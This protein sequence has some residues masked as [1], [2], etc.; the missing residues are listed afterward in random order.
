MTKNFEIQNEI[1]VKDDLDKKPDDEEKIDFAKSLENYFDEVGGFLKDLQNLH[2]IE[3]FDADYDKFEITELSFVPC[4]VDGDPIRTAKASRKIDNRWLEPAITD[5][6]Y[7]I[8]NWDFLSDCLRDDKFKTGNSTSSGLK[9]IYDKSKLKIEV[10]ASKSSPHRAEQLAEKFNKTFKLYE[11][12]EDE[13]IVK[14]IYNN[15]SFKS[16]NNQ[17]FIVTRLPRGS[18]DAL[19]TNGAK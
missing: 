10:S 16:E 17:V 6:T 12:D 7:S 11:I 19:L 18:L 14:Q 8:E 15:T 5:A 2:L 4:N 3:K 1:D 13:K 9:L